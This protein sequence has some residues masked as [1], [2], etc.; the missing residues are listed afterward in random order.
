MTALWK[1]LTSTRQ[2]FA[3]GG[4]LSGRSELVRADRVRVGMARWNL[5]S[6][7]RG[8]S[9]RAGSLPHQHLG[10][11]TECGPFLELLDGQLT[12]RPRGALG[13]G[14][15]GPRQGH[16]AELMV[17]HGQ[18]IQVRDEELLPLAGEVG[19]EGVGRLAVPADAVIGHA[20]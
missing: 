8:R 12:W 14:V 5:A 15:V 11:R 19:P 13:P 4:A 1:T 10:F 6:I 16:L 18:E 7:P 17:A 20:Q 9:P 2:R 3:Q